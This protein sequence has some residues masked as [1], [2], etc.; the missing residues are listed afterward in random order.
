MR[1]RSRRDAG[2]GWRDPIGERQRA[3]SPRREVGRHPVFAGPFR[4]DL[5]RRHFDDGI[6]SEGTEVVDAEH[7]IA[8]AGN[9]LEGIPCRIAGVAHIHAIARRAHRRVVFRIGL[10][11]EPLRHLFVVPG[12]TDGITAIVGLRT[13]HHA[14]ETGAVALGFAIDVVQGIVA[15]HREQHGCVE[16]TVLV[17]RRNARR[18]ERREAGRGGGVVAGVVQVDVEPAAAREERRIGQRH[19]R[20]ANEAARFGE[21]GLLEDEGD[22][23]PQVTASS[24]TAGRSGWL[25]CASCSAQVNSSAPAMKL[26]SCRLPVSAR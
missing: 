12:E 10:A 2:A 9:L 1:G 17:Q 5:N 21:H 23:R 3:A 14:G 22:K 8:Q 16:G 25:V 19:R 20:G 13:V 7:Q 11:I 18:V 4:S 15:V 26:D 24:R 6:T